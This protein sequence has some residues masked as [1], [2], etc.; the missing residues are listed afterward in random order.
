MTVLFFLPILCT[1][2]T[3]L[4]AIKKIIIIFALH[5]NNILHQDIS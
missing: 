1:I 3:E 5:M 2:F 4:F